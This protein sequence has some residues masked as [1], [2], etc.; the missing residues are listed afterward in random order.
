MLTPCQQGRSLLGLANQVHPSRSQH[1]L[2]Q[3]PIP[4]RNL[5]LLPKLEPCTLSLS[6]N[7][8]ATLSFKVLG[9]MASPG[10]VL[11]SYCVLSSGCLLLWATASWESGWSFPTWADTHYC[12]PPTL[13]HLCPWGSDWAKRPSLIVHLTPLPRPTDQLAASKVTFPLLSGHRSPD[14][15]LPGEEHGGH[16]PQNLFLPRQAMMCLTHKTE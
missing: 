3:T 9:A 2:R 5:S 7:P 4:P 14:Y 11:L 1:F 6:P 15:V 13:C 12:T 8:A 16:L 10:S